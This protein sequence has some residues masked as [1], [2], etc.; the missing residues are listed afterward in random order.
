[1]A[2]PEQRA[3]R[4]PMKKPGFC[5]AFSSHKTILKT[6]QRFQNEQ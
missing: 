1:M 3:G 5:R 2:G 6:Q 4:P